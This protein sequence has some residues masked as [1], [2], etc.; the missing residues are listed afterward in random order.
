M[1]QQVVTT[2]VD[3][4]AFAELVKP[5][6]LQKPDEMFLFR[7]SCGNAHF[8]HAGYVE[9]LMPFARADGEEKVSKDSNTVNVCTTCRNCYVWYN[10]AMYDVTAFVDLEA[11]E[12]AE[13][14]LHA[15]TGPGGQC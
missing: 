8:R 2:M 12:K 3:K 13:R 1:D 14:E 7:C 9:T 4:D 6:V 11:W 5:K 15:A 10:E